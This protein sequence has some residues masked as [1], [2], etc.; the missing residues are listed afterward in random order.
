VGADLFP[1]PLP[2]LLG[3]AVSVATIILSLDLPAEE[4]SLRL[5]S[6]LIG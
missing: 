1:L 3:I 4:T 5:L 2:S 6:L